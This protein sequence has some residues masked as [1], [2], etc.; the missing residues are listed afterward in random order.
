MRKMNCRM[1]AAALVAVQIAV[2]AMPATAFAAENDQIQETVQVVQEQAETPA[3][4]IAPV[5][6]VPAVVAEA[7]AKEEEAAPV[8]VEAPA[9]DSEEEA[10]ETEAQKESTIEVTEETEAAEEIKTPESEPATANAA[11]VTE[12]KEE[13]KAS[14]KPAQGQVFDQTVT[15]DRVKIKVTAEEGA[16]EEGARLI[17]AR[18][19][20]TQ[21]KQVENAVADARAKDELVTSA[22]AFDIKIVNQDRQALQPAADKKVKV[23]FE[24]EEAADGSL[25]AVVYHIVGPK[26][27][28]KAKKLTTTVNSTAK[29]AEVQTD[30][31]SY[32]VVEFVSK[33]SIDAI[34]HD[35]RRR[36][37]VLDHHGGRG[38]DGI[39]HDIVHVVSLRAGADVVDGNLHV[40]GALQRIEVPAQVRHIADVARVEHPRR[41]V[42]AN[43][44]EPHLHHLDPAAFESLELDVQHVVAGIDI[45]RDARA[46]EDQVQSGPLVLVEVARLRSPVREVLP[47]K[48][49]DVRDAGERLPVIDEDVCVGAERDRSSRRHGQGERQVAG[50]QGHLRA[51]GKRH[52]VALDPHVAFGVLRERRDAEAVERSR[53]RA[54]AERRRGVRGVPCVR[55]AECGR[56]ECD[57]GHDKRERQSHADAMAA[58]HRA[59]STEGG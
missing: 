8:E 41:Y 24:T 30:G 3:K 54:A 12:N 36:E 23:S 56:R 22:Y 16:F 40:D 43:L 45:V 2:T 35:A 31:L 47:G 34:G 46:V 48:H 21:L 13:T 5:E 39:H 32:Y 20:S 38:Y 27:N 52:R 55:L 10:I 51:G 7:P 4:E 26:D 14:E 50:C 17:A 19:P 11:E 6:E 44:R 18:V 53:H 15:V 9:E 57:R 33:S 29:T 25:G 37:R 49:N 28:I 59:T 1:L 42:R 58:L